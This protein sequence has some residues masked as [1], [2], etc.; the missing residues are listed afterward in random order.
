MLATIL[1]LVLSFTFS[2]LAEAETPP[3]A[4]QHTKSLNND[5]RPTCVVR[6]PPNSTDDT[7]VVLEAFYKCGRAGNSVFLNQTYHINTVMN[8]TGLKDCEIDLYGTM[9]VISLS[10]K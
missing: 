3:H 7:S 6:T 5:H 1:A 10:S 9:L 4:N 2:V 8:T